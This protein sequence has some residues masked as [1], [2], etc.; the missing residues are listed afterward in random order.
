MKYEFT[1]EYENE[2]AESQKEIEVI[3]VLP[4]ENEKIPKFTVVCLIILCML[5]LGTG[6]FYWYTTYYLESDI[7]IVADAGGEYVIETS[8]EPEPEI[9][10]PEPEPTINLPPRPVLDVRPE[11]A[12]IRR[13]LSNQNIIGRLII[14]NELDIFIVQVENINQ[15]EMELGFFDNRLDVWFDFELNIIIQGNHESV[16]QSVLHEYFEY[17]FFLMNPIIHFNTIYADYMFEIFSFYVAPMDFIDIQYDEDEWGDTIE[18]FRELGFYNTMLDV[19]EFDQV[20]TI[21]TP[22]STNQELYYV[23]QA[24]LYREITS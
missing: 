17:D 10:E 11:F 1:S 24:R 20:L 21:T 9:I 2:I 14:E 22:T 8:P 15:S 12:Q 7:I 19:T 4:V 13:E 23:L 5:S 16:L 6:V 18:F 3:E